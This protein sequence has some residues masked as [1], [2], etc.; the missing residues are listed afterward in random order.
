MQNFGGTKHSRALPALALIAGLAVSAAAPT[1]Q[2]ELTAAVAELESI[3]RAFTELADHLRPHVV[4]IAAYREKVKGGDFDAAEPFNFG[5]GFFYAEGGRILTNNHVIDGAGAIAVRLSDGRVLRADV[6]GSDAKADLALLDVNLDDAPIAQT[7]KT[8]NVRVGHWALTLGNPYGI[9]QGDGN[10]PLFVG[11]VSAMHKS[12][13]GRF[14]GPA[15]DRDYDDMIQTDVTLQPGNSGGPIF[16]VRGEVI[17]IATAVIPH[18]QDGRYSSFAIPFTERTMKAIERLG[19]GHKAG[20][21]FFGVETQSP[22]WHSQRDMN[23]TGGAEITR[24]SGKGS[25]NPAARAN[26]RRGDIITTFGRMPV[27]GPAHLDKLVEHAPVGAPIDVAYVSKTGEARETKVTLIGD[28]L[29]AARNVATKMLTWRGTMLTEINDHIRQ[30]NRLPHDMKGLMLGNVPPKSDLYAAGL[31]TGTIITQ[32]GGN[33]TGTIEA[34]IKCEDANPKNVSL[35]TNKN[36]EIALTI[37][38]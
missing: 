5:S 18:D 30:R 32:C 21:P 36:E 10:A 2:A 16:N 13:K 27:R 9:A 8:E 15:D 23:I 26:L 19:Q 22:S 14:G 25:E 4:A 11:V 24:V 20:T 29:P 6:I 7:A 35:T 17:G 37:G 1:A 12:I 28:S 34:F 31:R 38:D 33:P 3:E